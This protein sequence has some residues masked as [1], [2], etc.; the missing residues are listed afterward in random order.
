MIRVLAITPAQVQKANAQ[1]KPFA[2][3]DAAAAAQA[4]AQDPGAMYASTGGQGPV[5]DDGSAST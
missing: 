4:A 3:A 1:Y 2:G 5:P